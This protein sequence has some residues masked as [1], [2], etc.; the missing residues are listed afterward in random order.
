MKSS[1][2]DLTIDFLGHVGV[3]AHIDLDIEGLPLIRMSTAHYEY[4]RVV[5]DRWYL[6]LFQREGQSFF[7]QKARGSGETE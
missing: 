1:E 5:I 6:L 7:R 3:I 2:F 4:R